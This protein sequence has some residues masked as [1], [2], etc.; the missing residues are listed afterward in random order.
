MAMDKMLQL[1]GLSIDE[2]LNELKAKQKQ[3]G[4]MFDV[5]INQLE[6]QKNE[7]KAKQNALATEQKQAKIEEDLIR[8]VLE[9]RTP[10]YPGRI[11]QLIAVEPEAQGMP[12]VPQG[13]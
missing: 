2:Q 3:I 5:Q 13:S 4:G 11:D 8:S 10:Q 1:Q 9:S 7:N 12:L 6:L